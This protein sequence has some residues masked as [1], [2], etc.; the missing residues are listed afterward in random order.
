MLSGLGPLLASFTLA[1]SSPAP[2]PA[3]ATKPENL[4][5]LPG[6]LV[7]WEGKATET[8]TMGNRKF[9][10]V[11]TT[12]WFPIDLLTPEGAVKLGRVRNGVK[13][14]VTIRVAPNP[15]PEESLEVDDRMVHLS[16]ADRARVE[17]EE[18]A[19][20]G[21]W[22]SVSPPVFKLPLGRPIAAKVPSGGFGTRRLFNGEPR[23]PHTGVDYVANAGTP[24]LAADAGVLVLAEE[25]FFPGQCVFVDHGGELVSMYFHLSRIDVKPG[26]KVRRGQRVGTVGDSGRAIGTHLHFGLRWHGA[27]IDPAQLLRS[28]SRVPS[29]PKAAVPVQD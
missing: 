22:N 26:D 16:A 19:V 24:V 4:L 17:R 28:P 2:A 20:E 3:G 14:R 7:R 29:V 1:A 6:T 9:A 8:C 13:E 21:V 15:Y 23:S 25:Q 10:P 12:C 18:A 11:G 5:V 27:R